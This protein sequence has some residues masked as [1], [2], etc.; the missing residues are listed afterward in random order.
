LEVLVTKS[1][2][3]GEQQWNLEDEAIATLKEIILANQQDRAP[4]PKQIER[5]KQT[6]DL[7]NRLK[8]GRED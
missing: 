5:G 4:T 2:T 7:L 8:Q 3:A 6:M 1:S